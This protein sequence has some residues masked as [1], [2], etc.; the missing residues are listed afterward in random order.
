MDLGPSDRFGP[1]STASSNAGAVSSQRRRL[2]RARALVPPFV[3]LP[4][5]EWQAML[6][7]SVERSGAAEAAPPGLTRTLPEQLGPDGIPVNVVV[8][9]VALTE[10][11]WSIL[12]DRVREL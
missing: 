9:G 11:R 10:R 4:A 5:E 7:T 2:G 6:R 1:R 12:P 3:E 8:P